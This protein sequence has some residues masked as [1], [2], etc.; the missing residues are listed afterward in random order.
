MSATPSPVRPTRSTVV[1]RV[2]LV[3]VLVVLAVV[4]LSPT[5]NAPDAL[6]TLVREHLAALGAPAWFTDP[7]RAEQVANVAILLPVGVLG[8]LALPQLSW[9]DW[10]AYAFVGALAVEAAQGLL[11]PQRQTSASDVVA[12]TLGLLLGALAVELVVVCARRGR[13]WHRRRV[14]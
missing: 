2:L 11:L 6:L 8:G 10:T 3:G 13:V 9:Q 12:N 14:G 4:V 1:A 5:S 7:V